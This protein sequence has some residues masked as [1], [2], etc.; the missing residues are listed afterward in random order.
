M[1]P[2][3]SPDAQITELAGSPRGPIPQR[4]L[5]P[6]PSSSPSLPIYVSKTLGESRSTRHCFCPSGGETRR[7][8]SK[9]GTSDSPPAVVC[10]HRPLHRLPVLSQCLNRT[11]TALRTALSVFRPTYTPYLNL[12]EP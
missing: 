8:A 9:A 6:L 10:H 5:G 4:G 11:R 7:M 2:P 12:I 1:S 3:I